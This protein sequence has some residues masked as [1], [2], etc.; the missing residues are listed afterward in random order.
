MRGTFL[1][2]TL[3]LFALA[4]AAGLFFL[5]SQA[6]A[7]SGGARLTISLEPA[8]FPNTEIGSDPAIMVATVT[9]E[10]SDSAFL[11]L[12]YVGDDV[13]F[14][15]PILE[16]DCLWARLGAGQS[17]NSLIYFEPQKRGHIDT[18]FKVWYNYLSRA[19]AAVRGYAYVP[20]LSP[21][22]NAVDFGQKTVDSGRETR[23]V[24]LFNKAL[25]PISVVELVASGAPFDVDQ[26]C[27]TS[28][29]SGSSCDVLIGFDPTAVGEFTGKVTV[30]DSYN[31]DFE[32]DLSGEGVA[33][34]QPDIHLST[35]SIAFG[36]QEVG[37]TSAAYPVTLV[38]T[39]TVAVTV[40]DITTLVG[41]DFTVTNAADCEKALAPAESCTIQVVFTPSAGGTR[42]G[43]ASVADDAPD[44]PQTIALSGLGYEPGEPAVELSAHDIDFGPQTV[45]TSSETHYIVLSNVGDASL[46]VDSVEA[47]GDF[48]QESDCVGQVAAGGRC[49]VAT[50]FT[51]AALGDLAGEVT[52]TDSA[53]GSPR[54]VALRGTGT[55]EAEPEADL[56]ATEI[57][58]GDQALESFTTRTLTIT[59]TGNSDL[60][61][62]LTTI[63]GEGAAEFSR[64]D[65]CR[66]S[67]VE[68]GTSCDVDIVFN[69]AKVASYTAVL[70]IDDNAA[71]APQ[72]VVLTGNGVYSTAGGCGITAGGPGVASGPAFVL[73]SLGFLAASRLRRRRRG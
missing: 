39:G 18:Y 3:S 28:I 27:V 8:Q 53:A 31:H 14:S 20:P 21:S 44:S 24:R 70:S 37:T 66:E 34:G 1:K 23:E 11:E 51:P 72:E 7:S 12:V 62:G 45:G 6:S 22:T 36:R 26:D 52:I 63:D 59:N 16:N 69:P 43:Q 17:C 35:S 64:T 25:V 19:Q 41:G 42:N 29:P 47:T 30:R 57:D 56:S 38:S 71:D 9:N 10:G 61:I 32:I 15:L 50:T 58:F 55:N 46:T 5:N 68:P 4:A 48:S 54:A 49:A 67:A 40:A 2:V 60:E 33:R 65:G 13:N 73:I